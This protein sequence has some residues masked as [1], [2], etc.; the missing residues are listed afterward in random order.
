MLVMIGLESLVIFSYAYF[1]NVNKFYG[2]AIS[3]VFSILT[4]IL[5]TPLFLKLAIY[6]AGFENHK[7]QDGYD[8]SLAYKTFYFN[9]IINYMLLLYIGILKP[10]VSGVI[11]ARLGITDGDSCSSSNS[12]FGM[13]SLALLFIFNQVLHF[14]SATYIINGNNFCGI[15]SINFNFAFNY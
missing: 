14:C 5:F 8:N 11:N 1:Y 7:S 13:Q 6:T 10:F 9:F 15:V 12:C 4:I 3:S 2:T